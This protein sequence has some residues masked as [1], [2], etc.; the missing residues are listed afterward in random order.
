MNACKE[1]RGEEERGVRREE[2]RGRKEKGIETGGNGREEENA[3]QKRKVG[4]VV[5]KDT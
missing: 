3:N 5:K 4:Q 1:G 2:G